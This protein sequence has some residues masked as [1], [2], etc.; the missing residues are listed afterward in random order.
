MLAFA[1]FVL[2]L[3]CN[4]LPDGKIGLQDQNQAFIPARVAV[5]PCQPWPKGA[6]FQGLLSSNVA[7]QDLNELCSS[8]DEFVLNGFSG[9]PYMRGLSPNLVEQLLE[10]SKDR[11]LR[12]RQQASLQ[13]DGQ[14]NENQ[15][16]TSS[17]MTD[18]ASKQTQEIVLGKEM[19][20]M[21]PE[22]W[23]QRADSC[24]PCLDSI[25]YYKRSIADRSS[26][27]DWLNKFS[28]RVFNADSVLLPFVMYAQEV[29]GDDR[30]VL[31]AKREAQVRL[32]LIDTNNGQLIWAGGRTASSLNRDR[33]QLEADKLSFPDWSD[34]SNRLFR[35]DIWQEYPGRQNF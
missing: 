16:A 12:E 18:E 19:I 10:R 13:E 34:L 20:S 33:N 7:T 17:S 22:L 35:I 24:Q 5:L 28:R 27:L 21:V 14:V 26:W 6:P 9:Q 15:T 2:S 25:A 8:F 23:H 30:G 3:S 32:F 4:T 11:L 29:K 31:I 1:M